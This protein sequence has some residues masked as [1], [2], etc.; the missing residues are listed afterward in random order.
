MV[1]VLYRGPWSAALASHAE[2]K[3]IVA[4]ASH[5]REGF[6]VRPT[7]ERW[8]ERVQRVILKLIGEEYLLRKDG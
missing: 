7:M 3:S 6:V 4:T 5:I 1:P 8:D 2:G